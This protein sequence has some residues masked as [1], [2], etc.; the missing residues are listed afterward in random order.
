MS[1]ELTKRISKCHEM[2]ASM[3]KEL[4]PPKMQIPARHNE[5]NEDIFIGDTLDM[6]QQELAELKAQNA[7]LREALSF[8][9]SK[10]YQS[11]R[12]WAKSISEDQG[13]IANKALST[14]P[15]EALEKQRKKDEV[16]DM[17]V[18]AVIWMSGSKD[19][20]PEGIA[21]GGFI[22]IVEPAIKAAK[23]LEGE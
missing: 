1:D 17:L 5:Y 15:S 12:L 21:R 7:V 14:T 18:E 16:F 8:Y 4:R 6:C 9:S 3:C 19:F 13:G 22:K 23:E 10:S 11:K 2:I 20:S